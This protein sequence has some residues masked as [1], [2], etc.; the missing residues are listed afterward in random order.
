MNLSPEKKIAGVLAPLFALRREDDLGIGDVEALRQFIEWI[1]ESGFKL[2][3]LLPINEI[4]GDHSPYNAISAMAIEPTTLHLAPGSPQDLSAEDFSAVTA[5]VDLAELRRGPV[6]YPQVRKLKKRLLE[7]AFS[8]FREQ[9]DQDRQ[10]DFEEFCEQEFAWLDDYAFFRALMEENGGRENWDE[11]PYQTLGAA[12]DWFASL[13]SERQSAFAQ[14]QNFF[15]YV[16]WIAHQQWRDVK[17]FA[18]ARDVA[19]MGDIPFGISYYSADVFAQQDEFALDWS[20]GA[21]PEP[22]FKDDAV[23][24]KMGAKLGRPALSL[25]RDAGA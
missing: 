10:S 11:W 21:P 3:Q 13:S 4:G 24:A 23:H 15:C 1:A 18:Q 14:R 17:A 8:Q 22:Y 19:L 12:R 20:A 25:G 2:V 9:A 16:Q 6:R 5:D 7:K